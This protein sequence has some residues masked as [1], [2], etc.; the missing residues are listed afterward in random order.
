MTTLAPT[1]VAFE[2]ILIPTDFST[3]SDNALEYAKR[4]AKLY[5]SKLLLAHV[6]EPINPVSPPEAVWIDEEE[7]RQQEVKQLEQCSW[8]ARQI[9]YQRE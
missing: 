2:R 8:S 7:I 5:H 6:N 3:I 4:I 1:R 9:L